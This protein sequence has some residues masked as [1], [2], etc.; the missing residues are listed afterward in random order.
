MTQV[1]SSKLVVGEQGTT[2]QPR[3]GEVGLIYELG[4]KRFVASK[5]RSDSAED[6]IMRFVVVG[7]NSLQSGL[8]T[9]GKGTVLV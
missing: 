5:F 8:S 7:E 1:Q 2:G 9:A 6:E 4:N 3:E